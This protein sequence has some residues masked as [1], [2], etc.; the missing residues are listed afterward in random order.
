MEVKAGYKQTEVGV[1]PEDWGVRLLPDVCRFRGGKAH[2]Q[3]ISEFGPFVCVNSKFISTDGRVRKYSRVNFCCAKR[4]DILM[5]M[6]DLPNG[7]A[8]AK[9]Y[10][11]DREDL[12]AVNQR[13]CALTPY[14]DSSRYLF[15]ALNRNPYFLKF[16]DGVNQTHLL[17]HVFQ[18][19]PL[20]L[21][22]TKA[23]QEAIAEA[24]IDGDA[25][26]ESLEQLLAKKRHLKRGAMQE[27]ITGK[28]RLPG[29]GGEWEVKL[30]GDCFA[31]VSTRNTELNDNV[32]TISA[33]QGFVRQEEFFKKRV[34]SSVLEHYYLIERGHFAYNR[35]Y[36]NGYPF[37]AISG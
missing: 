6:S 23:E 11:A 1:I 33:Q 3:H 30:L 17:N 31:L 26:I 35:S 13:V 8:L 4:D 28:K 36:S 2:E 15:Y 18:K 22:P 37:G 14:R 21:P 16:D 24:L 34:A 10:L 20:P 25:F 12:Y 7:R 27:L 19:C 5:V 29:F 9:A 32:V